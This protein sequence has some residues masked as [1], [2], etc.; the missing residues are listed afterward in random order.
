METRHIYQHKLDKV[1]FQHDMVCD[2]FKDLAKI[3]VLDK[4]SRDKVFEIAK[5]P[6]FDRHQRGLV[7]II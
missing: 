1:F 3:T 5:Y 4:V 2:H 7:S 6:K